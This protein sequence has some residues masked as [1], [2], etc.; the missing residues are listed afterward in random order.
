[1][2]H[3]NRR[4]FMTRVVLGSA[5]L[6]TVGRALADPRTGAARPDSCATCQYYTPSPGA[7]SGTCAFAGKSVSAD[8]GCGEYTPAHASSQR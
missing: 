2:Q 1:M 5:A 3:L 4:L 8:G 7:A 6:A